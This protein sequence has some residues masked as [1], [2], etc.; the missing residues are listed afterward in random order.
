VPS[1]AIND[2]SVTEGNSGTVNAAFTVTLSAASAQTVTVD[3][4][5]ADGTAIAPADYL[6][7][8]LTTLSFTPG[9]TTR[10]INVTVNGDVLDE[11]DETFLVNLSNATNATISD[12]QGEGTITDD[13]PTPSL[14]INDV[15]A[16][17]GA[18]TMSFT[19]SLSAISGQDVSVDYTTT[20][21]SAVAPDDYTA[22][23]G[24]LTIAAGTGSDTLTVTINDD[25]I[26]E[27]AE[28]FT[29]DLSS[30]VNATISDNQGTGTITDNE[31][32]PSLA[33]DDVSVTEGNSGTVNAAFTVTLS[34]ASAQTVT[35]DYATAD[36]SATAPAD[37]LAQTLM[38]PA[39]PVRRSQCRSTVMCWTKQMKPSSLISAILLM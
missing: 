37:Y 4:V 20:D 27:S 15:T 30:A 3:Y 7:Q 26:P 16:D 21:S 13:D 29:V 39:S 38:T 18:G 17:E 6:A 31:G 1:L 33:I 8:T 32:V 25:A 11:T 22:T 36:G 2:V 9:T 24:T 19:V 34:A 28:S 23:S 12:N 5:T 14:S 35:V 10:T